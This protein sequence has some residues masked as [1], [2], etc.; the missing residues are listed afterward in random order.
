MSKTMPTVEQAVQCELDAYSD[1]TVVYNVGLPFSI[2]DR[3]RTAP[4]KL[5]KALVVR[6]DGWDFEFDGE[7]LP[8]PEPGDINSFSA[9]FLFWMLNDGYK[10]AV[11]LS[12]RPLA[13]PNAAT[14]TLTVVAPAGKQARHRK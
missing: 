9:P 7:A 6:I 14:S 4:D 1:V 3:Y 10:K 8:A 5:M 13:S 12:A 11:E 2:I